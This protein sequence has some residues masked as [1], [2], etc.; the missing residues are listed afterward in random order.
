MVVRFF[1]LV[2]LG[3]MKGFFPNH[4][5]DTNIVLIPKI[6]HPMSMKDFRPISL[7]KCDL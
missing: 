1:L 6:D 4:L 5:N 3:Y 7:C 2:Y